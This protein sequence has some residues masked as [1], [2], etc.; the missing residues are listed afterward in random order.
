MAEWLTQSECADRLGITPRQVYNLTRSVAGRP[1]IPSRMKE[2]KRQYK[3]PD[4]NQWYIDQKLAAAKPEKAEDEQKLAQT[5]KTVA[6]AS[7]KE[8][9]LAKQEGAL[10]DADYVE[11]QLTLILEA[12]RSRLLAARGRFAPQILGIKS[13]GDAQRRIEPLFDELMETLRRVPEDAALDEDDE[14]EAA[15][16]EPGEAAGAR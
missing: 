3:W 6:E 2:G 12:L 8:L 14:D 10:L 1:S 13:I 16:D 4:A 9:E 11:R 7:L 15:V 5:R